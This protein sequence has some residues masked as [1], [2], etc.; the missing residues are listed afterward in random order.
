M[1]LFERVDRVVIAVRDLGETRDFLQDLLATPFD[2]TIHDENVAMDVVMSGRFGFELVSPFDTNH[3]AAAL[4]AKAL[5]EYGPGT[6]VVVVKVSDM[7]AAIAHFRE[8][9]LEPQFQMSF[10]AAR[11][12]GY[13]LRDRL[14]ITLVLNEYTDEHPMTRQGLAGGSHGA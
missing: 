13:D 12:T 2:E 3:P 6:R 10:A 4:E 1:A 7:D 14:G 5:E 11:E 8:R 9:G